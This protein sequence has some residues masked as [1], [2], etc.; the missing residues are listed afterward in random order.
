MNTV[1]ELKT[2]LEKNKITLEREDSICITIDGLQIKEFGQLLR[3]LSKDILDSE[4]DG[5]HINELGKIY[6]NK[7]TLLKTIDDELKK[8][9]LFNEDFLKNHNSAKKELENLKNIIEKICAFI[10]KC[11]ELKLDY[12][13]AIIA[14]N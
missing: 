8:N 11:H 7:D 13:N 4:I 9:T 1:K 2:F 3:N 12:K 10:E 14:Y 6:D 5:F